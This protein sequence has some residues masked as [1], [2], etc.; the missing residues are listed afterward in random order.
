M[1]KSTRSKVKRSFRAKKRTTGVYAAVE[2]ARLNRLHQKLKVLTAKDEEGITE[3]VVDSFSDDERMEQPGWCW[4]AN[5]GLCD[6]AD[7]SPEYLQGMDHLLRR[8]APAASS[9]SS[10][11]RQRLRR[12]AVELSSLGS[13]DEENDGS[14]LFSHL[15]ASL[16]RTEVG[17]ENDD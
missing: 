1:A 14:A 11:L 13:N 5:F 16:P 2:A 9:G 4:F 15:F 7:F 8:T 3:E 12:D 6:P 17:S 10:S